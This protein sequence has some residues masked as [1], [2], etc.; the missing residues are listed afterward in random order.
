M[1]GAGATLSVKQVLKEIKD[2]ELSEDRLSIDPQAII[3]EDTDITQEEG[4]LEV[5]G[6]TNP[7]FPYGSIN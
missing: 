1:I 7:D 4:T 3:I 6:S 2:L 5:I